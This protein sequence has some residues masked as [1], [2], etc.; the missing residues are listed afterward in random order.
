MPLSEAIVK[1]L[2]QRPEGKKTT[3]IHMSGT[4]NFVDEGTADNAH[5]ENAKVWNIS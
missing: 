2:K 3:L 1:G 5:N 4:G